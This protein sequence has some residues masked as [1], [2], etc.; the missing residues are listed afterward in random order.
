MSQ[1]RDTALMFGTGAAIPMS[2]SLVAAQGDELRKAGKIEL[3]IKAYLAVAAAAEIP[4]ASICLK[5][6]RCYERLGNSAAAYRWALAVVDAGDDFPS[7]Q[8]A[9]ALM[10]R[11]STGKRLTGR[12]SARVALVGSFTTGQ[13]AQMLWLAVSRLGIALEIYESHYDQYRQ[14][15]ID[16]DSKMYKFAPDFVVL[17][18]HEGELSLPEY[19]ASPQQDVEAELGRWTVLWRTVAER[20]K[21]RVVQFNFALPCEMPM[22]HLGARLPGT[23]YMMAQAV[24]A[25]L[26]ERAGSTV[27]IVDCERLSAIFGKQRWLDPRYW[28]LAKQAVALDAL[29][30]L[31]RHT[32]AVIAAEL[33]LSRKCLVLD[34]D[35]TLWGGIIGE[36]GVAGIKLGNDIDGAAFVAFQEYL[37]RLKNKGVI[38]TV[39][40]KNNEAD[41]KEPFEKHPEMRIKLNDIAMFVANWQSKPD[42]IRSI[43]KALNL[44]LDTV[45]LVDDNPVERA[46]VR[47]LIP[48]VDVLPLPPDP[49]QYTR[50]LSQYLLFEASWYTPEDAKR[51][52]QYRSRTRILEMEASAGSIEDFYRSLQMQ[53]IVAPFDDFSLPRIAQLIGKTNQFNVTTRRHGMAQLRV[54][55]NDPDYVHFFLRLRDRLSDHGLVSL[56]IALRQGKVLDIDTWLMSCRVI[57]RTVEATMLAQ[58]CQWAERLGCESIRGTYIPAARNEMAKDVFRQF[59]FT[60]LGESAGIATWVYDLHAK[61]PITNEFIKIVDSWENSNGST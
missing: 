21:A 16:S 15:I 5:L 50:A 6:A 46:A 33:G 8:T 34:L 3:A 27:S 59:G 45:V 26:G 2:P 4:E 51:T 17:A 53:A 10:Q 19:S 29:P 48:E 52:D 49:T 41:A 37:L 30:L 36:D 13:L 44:G 47:Q 39:C 11:C 57:G 60:R 43:A 28:Y 1:Q 40:S 35:G 55:M 18:V 31:A 25:G 20:S 32:A 61:G 56:L 58:L 54:F 38:L 7:W 23:R 42:N 22:G 14:E 24:N 9:S 12:R